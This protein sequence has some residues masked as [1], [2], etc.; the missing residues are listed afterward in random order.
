MLPLI[1]VGFVICRFIPWIKALKK[2]FGLK[3]KCADNEEKDNLD[4]DSNDVDEE[5]NSRLS[6]N[7]RL[8]VGG[9]SLPTIAITLDRVICGTFGIE[10]S[11]IIRTSMVF[12]SILIL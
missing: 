4:Y 1:P 11:S 7:I 8:F 10:G 2:L 6:K 9:L 3:Q 12:Y 5:E